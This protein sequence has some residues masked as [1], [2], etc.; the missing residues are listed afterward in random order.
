MMRCPAWF[1]EFCADS[2]SAWTMSL[3]ASPK[4]S[5]VPT[6][7]SVERTTPFNNRNVWKGDHMFRPV[8]AQIFVLVGPK[9][10]T[11]GVIEF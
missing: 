1:T 9:K 6:P 2:R 4:D 5:S 7:S 3:S 8:M 11:A 10:N